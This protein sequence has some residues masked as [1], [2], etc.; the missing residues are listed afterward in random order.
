[1]SSLHPG[2]ISREEAEAHIAPGKILYL[3]VMFPHESIANDKY[4][5]VVGFHD[6]P[7]L[8]KINS[9]NRMSQNNKRMREHQFRLE[10]SQYA[11]LQYDSYLDCGRVWYMLSLEEIVSQLIQEPEK[12]IIGQISKEHENE[13][14]RLVNRSGSV[15][16]IHRRCVTQAFHRDS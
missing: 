9:E 8:L 16:P 7:L 3:N 6:R 11:F 1:M 12:R 13:V 14:V 15:G 10:S 4:F 2:Q 5:V